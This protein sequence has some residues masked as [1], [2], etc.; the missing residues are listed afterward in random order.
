MPVKGGYLLLAGA[1]GLLLYSGVKGKSFSSA[2]RNLLSGKSPSTATNA[3]TITSAPVT[4]GGPNQFGTA[5]ASGAALS[6]IAKDAL[7]YRGAGY[8]WGG[9]PADGIGNWDCSSF[10]NWVCGHDL[11]LAIPGY[12]AGSYTGASHG[13]TTTIWLVWDGLSTVGHNGT[14]APAGDLAIWETH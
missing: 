5:V 13:P 10:T 6:A 2:F 12:P 3:N 14:E 8:V 9:A 11:S 7:E 1:G 4:S